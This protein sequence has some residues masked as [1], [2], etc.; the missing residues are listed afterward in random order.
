MKL[1]QII[2]EEYQENSKRIIKVYES[3]EEETQE[4]VLKHLRGEYIRLLGVAPILTQSYK[5]ALY[6]EGEIEKVKKS[7]SVLKECAE[8]WD[9]ACN[10]S[11]QTTK[12]ES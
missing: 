8:E 12:G 1:S 2:L 4:M 7:E 3:F 11:G 6:M 9:K 5:D 10:I